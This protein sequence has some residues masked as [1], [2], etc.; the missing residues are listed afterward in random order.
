MFSSSIK[1]WKILQDNVSSLTL[2]PL[3]Q[4]RW[5]SWIESVKAIKF[6]ALEVRDALLQFAKTSEDPDC[7]ATYELESFEFLLGMTI[8]YDILF[9]VNSVSKNLQSKVMHID[10]AID[11]LKGLISFFKKYRNDGFTSAMISSK[12]IA[13]KMEIES[14]FHEKRIIRKKKQF[15]ENANDEIT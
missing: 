7:L 6:Q 13:I 4:T 8:W 14:I 1:R 3:L 5:E 11:Q 2:K 10:F 15:N 12:E 9:A